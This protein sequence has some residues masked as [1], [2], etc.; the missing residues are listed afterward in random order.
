MI[1][2]SHFETI[3]FTFDTKLIYFYLTRGETLRIT[4]FENWHSFCLIIKQFKLLGGML[5]GE[6]MYKK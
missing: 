3:L 1:R 6:D 2:L 5:Y 4:T